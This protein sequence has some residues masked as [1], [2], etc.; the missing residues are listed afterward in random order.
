MCITTSETLCISFTNANFAVL[1]HPEILSFSRNADGVWSGIT[2]DGKTFNQYPVP[3]SY[4]LRIERFVID[5]YTHFV[6]E[7]QIV[8]SLQDL[9]VVLALSQEK[10]HV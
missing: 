8:Y 6:V 2:V 3:N 1:P 5:D 9:S 10:P 7:G 4:G